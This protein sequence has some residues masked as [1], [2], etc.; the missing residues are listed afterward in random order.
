MRFNSG[1]IGIYFLSVLRGFTD[2]LRCSDVLNNS[3]LPCVEVPNCLSSTVDITLDQKSDFSGTAQSYS[4]LYICYDDN[5]FQITQNNYDQ[6]ITTQSSSINQCNDP[7]SNSNSASVY[8]AVD[9]QPVISCY[10]ELDVSPKNISYHAGV[11]VP[12]I[13]PIS[14]Q[15]FEIECSSSGM[16]S[17]TYQNI[18]ASMW[19][20]NFSISFDTISCPYYCPTPNSQ[21]DNDRN[22]TAPGLRNDST[23]EDIYRANF[24]RVTE[25]AKLTG[26]GLCTSLQN[27]GKCETLA[28]SPTLNLYNTSNFGYLLPQF[29]EDVYSYDGN[30]DQF[31]IDLSIIIGIFFVLVMIIY[32]WFVPAVPKLTGNRDLGS[33]GVDVSVGPSVDISIR[34]LSYYVSESN[35]TKD[36]NKKMFLLPQIRKTCNK[37]LLH[38]LNL[39]I[40]RNGVTAIMG[41]SGN[42]FFF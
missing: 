2:S 30:L 29:Q 26:N 12:S 1:L 23:I 32:V 16:T 34:N 27:D 38:S 36:Q 4:E 24:F 19:Q 17:V 9:N 21:C 25:T 42:T 11:Y 5:G 13:L 33:I 39:T 10:T 7:V 18:A 40:K 22:S 31:Y 6:L 20:V 37:Q 15:K 35:S 14:V 3:S 41:P 28:W 8:I